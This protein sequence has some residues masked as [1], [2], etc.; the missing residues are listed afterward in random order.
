MSR[1]SIAR[2]DAV[3][4][5]VRPD[6]HHALV[7]HRG[8]DAAER[9]VQLP[10]Q[11]GL[12]AVVDRGEARLAREHAGVAADRGDRGGQLV[13]A[14]DGLRGDRLLPRGLVDPPAGERN[15]E[16]DERPRSA[17][18]PTAVA[19][20]RGTTRAPSSP[21][22]RCPPRRAR[23]SCRRR[24]GRSA[25]G[26]DSRRASSRR[27]SPTTPRRPPAATASASR[28]ACE[29]RERRRHHAEHSS[30]GSSWMS[31][32]RPSTVNNGCLPRWP[33][34]SSAWVAARNGCPEPIHGGTNQ[35]NGIETSPSTTSTRSRGSSH[36]SQPRRR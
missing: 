9:H 22:A 15:R 16:R 25:R 1:G 8:P 35:K 11:R 18:S 21:A 12:D 14:G 33:L 19:P 34:Y 27:R 3:D 10:R 17:R 4:R 7:A 23:R 24:A 2:R 29:P 26:P 13:E 20:G 36:H 31:T 30:T 5:V 28:G 6:E 32:P